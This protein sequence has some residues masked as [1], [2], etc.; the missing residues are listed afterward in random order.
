LAGM[1]GLKAGLTGAA[2]AMWL[3]L[4]VKAV[5]LAWMG[6]YQRRRGLEQCGH[7]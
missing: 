4:R 7:F 5:L 1:K 2:V 6:V 3:S